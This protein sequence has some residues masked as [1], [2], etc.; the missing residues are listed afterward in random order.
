MRNAQSA[1]KETEST[2]RAGDQ[3]A[4]EN[5]LAGPGQS[6]QPTAIQKDEKDGGAWSTHIRIHTI[7]P[8][9]V[10]Y[11]RRQSSQCLLPSTLTF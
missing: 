3:A 6:E 1:R 4:F 9:D 8:V 10:E 2:P 5:H 7:P 11:V